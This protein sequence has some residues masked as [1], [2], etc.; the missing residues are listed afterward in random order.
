MEFVEEFPKN[1]MWGAATS[2]YQ[3]EGAALEDGKKENQQDVINRQIH[4]EYGYADASVTT[5]H[6]HHYK[7]DVALM[8]EMGFQSYRFSMN[9][10]RILPDGVGEPNPKGVQFY[11][12]LIK[13]LRDHNIEPIVTMWHYDLPMALVEKYGGWRDRQIVDDFEYYARFILNEYK[14]EVKYWLT[15]NEQSIVVN[16]IDRKN[17]ISKEDMFNPKFRWQA[18]HYMNLAHAKAAIAAHEI[19]KDVQ[20]GAALDT[21]PYYAASSDPKDVMAGKNANAMKNYFYMDAYFKGIYTPSVL[22]Y[23]KR[24]GLEFE[25]QDG[26]MDIIK[27][28]SENM[29]FLGINYYQSACMKAPTPGAARRFKQ[30]NKIGKGGKVTYEIQPDFY[31]GCHNDFL[32]DTDFSFPI[33]PDGLQ[34]VL[35]EINDRYGVPVMI[36]ENGFGAY[37]KLEKDGSIHDPYRIEYIREHIKAMKR[38][39]ANGVT[40]IAYNPWSAFDLLSTSN[41]IAKRYGFIYVDRTDDE[42]RDCKRYRKDSFYWYQRVIASNGKNLE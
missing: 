12:D 3:C 15:I 6:Y 16:Y 37:D 2:A 26:D 35:E 32:Q 13:E 39:I 34:Y 19:V 1:F 27:K 11:H 36:C 10:S 38:A 25:I 23:L 30:N 5:D 40:I 17:L 41:G 7:E 29:D 31:E 8:A 18:N 14:D 4:E 22:A 9:W 24:Q 28:G 33:D 42:E 21:A 20:V